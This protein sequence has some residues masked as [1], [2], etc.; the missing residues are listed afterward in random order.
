MSCK[1]SGPL[2]RRGVRRPE[3]GEWYR[4]PTATSCVE[5]HGGTAV[6]QKFPGRVVYVHPAGRYAVLEFSGSVGSY[7]ESF[8]PEELAGR[9]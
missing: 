5:T 6:R 8:F 7:R 1:S 2:C 9:A 3:I 4:V